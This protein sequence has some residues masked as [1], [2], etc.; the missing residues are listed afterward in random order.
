MN[1]SAEN[2]TAPKLSDE[3]RKAIVECYCRLQHMDLVVVEEG[4][5]GGIPFD[6]ILGV[7]MAANLE[8]ALGVGIPEDRLMRTSI[9][10]SLASFAAVVQACVDATQRSSQ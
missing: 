3:V 7:E 6:S 5:N 1:V 4:F 8:I 2:P 9:Y 10:S